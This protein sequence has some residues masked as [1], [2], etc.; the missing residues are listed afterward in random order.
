MGF[1]EA[2]SKY[3]DFIFPTGKDQV[4][5]IMEVAGKPPKTLLDVAC[6]TGGYSIELAQKGYAVTAVDL[7]SKMVDSLR[8]KTISSNLNINVLQGNMLELKGSINCSYDLAFCI[9]N[10]LVHLDG[11]KE[12]EAFLIEM[13]SLLVEGGSIVLQI[14]NYDRVLKMDIRSLPTIQ[15]K[16]VGLKFQRMYRYDHNINKVLFKTILEVD[17]NKIENEIPLYPI[18]L[19]NIVAL[20]KKAGFIKLGL[21]GDF[22]GREFDRDNSYALVIVAS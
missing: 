16:E 14:I 13:K 15:N 2:I 3:Y 8:N 6:G 12:I 11:E 20:L 7:D 5:F 10:S 22:D 9:G 17:G 21:F 1:Y 19:D 18:L 4:N